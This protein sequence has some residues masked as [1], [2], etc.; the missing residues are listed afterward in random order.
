MG[1]YLT[2]L[3]FRQNAAFFLFYMYTYVQ[4]TQ[5][6]SWSIRNQGISS[7]WP[8]S[9]LKFLATLKKNPLG[10]VYPLS[11]A[12]NIVLQL[13]IFNL[14]KV[15]F[16]FLSLNCEYYKAAF[17]KFTDSFMF[18]LGRYLR[19]NAF[20]K[21][22]IIYNNLPFFHFLTQFSFPFSFLFLVLR[23]PKTPSSLQK[24]KKVFVCVKLCLIHLTITEERIFKCLMGL[25]MTSAD[26][27]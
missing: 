18:K 20:L 9:P 10:F 27:S 23:N 4:H 2:F 3:H 8:A 1:W 19:S 14:Y 24:R 25:H 13:F 7:I 26:A 11:C 17:F 12:L 22:I 15:L 6:D 21:Y 5:I 16:L